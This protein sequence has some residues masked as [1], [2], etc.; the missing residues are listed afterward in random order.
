M[1]LSSTCRVWCEIFVFH[2]PN[3]TVPHCLQKI[4]FR[5]ITVS[6]FKKKIRTSQ[7]FEDLTQKT[8]A[9]PTFKHSAP[10]N[11]DPR[12]L[13]WE[14]VD[15]ERRCAQVFKTQRWVFYVCQVGVF[16]KAMTLKGLYG[17][18]VQYYQ[19]ANFCVTTSEMTSIVWEF[20]C[21]L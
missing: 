19:N 20:W 13:Y 1:R 21:T 10:P 12:C 16:G 2:F 8:L 5:N 15:L 4:T 3:D 9:H 17:S 11:S 18:L 6:P 7:R 14:N